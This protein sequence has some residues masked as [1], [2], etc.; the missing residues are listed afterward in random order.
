MKSIVFFFQYNLDAYLRE[1]ASV[2]LQCSPFLAI[3][4][5]E[6]HPC[7]CVISQV[8]FSTGNAKRPQ[9]PLEEVTIRPFPFWR[10]VA[11]QGVEV[12]LDTV[13]NV[14]T[15]ARGEGGELGREVECLHCYV[16]IIILENS[17][18]ET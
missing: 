12:E 1:A 6:K 17:K 14:A 11:V 18:Y 10:P 13:G 16:R 8:C 4:S 2:R 15:P 7:H 9:P 3:L 5:L